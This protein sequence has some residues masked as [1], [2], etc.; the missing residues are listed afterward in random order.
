MGVLEM[1]R[2]G[3]L[4][5]VR[6]QEVRGDRLAVCVLDEGWTPAPRIITMTRLFDLD[7]SRSEVAEHDGRMRAGDGA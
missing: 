6:G 4:V 1:E 5:A 3:L 2:D 7:D